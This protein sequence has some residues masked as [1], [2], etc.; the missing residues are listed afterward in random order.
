MPKRHKNLFHAIRREQFEKAVQNLH[1]RILRLARHEIILEMARIVAMVGDGHTNIYPTR[2]PKIGFHT[3]PINLYLFKDGLF[4]RAAEKEN[5]ALVGARV[6][7][8]G[9][10]SAEQAVTRVREIIGRD[11]EMDVQFFAPQ[12]LVMPEVL[13]GLRITDD[14]ETTALVIEKNGRERTVSL[15]PFR[16][17]EMM[18]SDVDLSWM[19]KEGWMDM[20]EGAKTPPPL[21][22]KDPQNKFWF[23]YLPDSRTVYVQLNQ[24]GDKETET[25][26][27][28]SKRLFA[29]VDSSGAEKLVL[30]LRLNRGGN[31]TLLPPLVA[32]IIQSPVNQPGRLFTIIGRSTFSAAQFLVNDLERYSNTLFV[33][34]PSGSKGNQYGDSRKIML[35]NSQLT[36]RVSI[37]YWQDWYP[38]DTRPW[39]A[40]HLTTELTSEHYSTNLDPAM[41]LIVGYVPQKPLGELLE[42]AYANN[43]VELAKSRFRMFKTDP[44]NRYYNVQE[45]MFA[46]GKRLLLSEKLDYAIEVLKLNTEADPKS[47][48]TYEALGDLYAA[49]KNKELAIKSYE[50]ALKLDPQNSEIEHKLNQLKQR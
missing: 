44:V 47:V 17:A 32:R 14:L 22:L 4:I 40:P 12:L 50:A 18:P 34:E 15:R 35:P 10:L 2:D 42:E 31:G 30:D 26:A 3:L 1:E 41:K 9:N 43:D 25:L 46:L 29:F 6:I 48:V 21:W 37:Y 39:T 28:F 27:A 20:R 38:W 45:E 36:V 49:R 24:V 13:H 5:A 23:E 8:I 11:N 33:G 16:L 19:T 7:R